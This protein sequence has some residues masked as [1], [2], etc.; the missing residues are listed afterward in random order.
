VQLLERFPVTVLRQETCN[1]PSVARNL[2]VEKARGDVIV[3]ID[4][5]VEVRPDTLALI[6]D[7]LQEHPE[8]AA[9]FGSYDNAPAAPGFISRFRNL[10]H[11]FVHQCGT[12]EAATFWCGCGA[13]RRAVYRELGGLSESFPRPS[14]EDIEFGTRAHEAGHTIHLLPEIQVK[15]LK[16]W[17]LSS[18][19]RTDIFNRAIP[20]TLLILGRRRRHWGLNLRFRH[21]MSAAL[22]FSAGGLLLLAAILGQLAL[23]LPAAAVMVVFHLLNRDLF[24]FFVRTEG[25]GFA[26]A[27]LPLLMLFY[28]YSTLAFGAGAVMHLLGKRLC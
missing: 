9:L 15:H 25:H 21:R 5:D 6:A 8:V 20:W 22:V 11:H 3:F 27:S 18:M 13:V 12:K 1:G 14:I 23:L 19:V 17:T 7:Y 24:H 26:L 4:A 16:P 2:G 10:M 28:S